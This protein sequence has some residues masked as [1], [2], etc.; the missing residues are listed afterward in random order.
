[1]EI[2]LK[3]VNDAPNSLPL[4]RIEDSLRF[5]LDAFADPRKLKPERLV[6]RLTTDKIPSVV[7][8]IGYNE[9]NVPIFMVSWSFQGPAPLTSCRY[10]D[11]PPQPES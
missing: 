1:M 5:A 4:D 8:G 11:S 7:N 6:V 3:W 9:K 10:Y 2:N